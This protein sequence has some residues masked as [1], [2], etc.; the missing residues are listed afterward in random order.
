MSLVSSPTSIFP[1]LSIHVVVPVMSP[2][3]PHCAVPSPVTSGALLRPLDQAVRW[4]R[5]FPRHGVCGYHRPNLFKLGLVVLIYMSLNHYRCC[6]GFDEGGCR[7]RRNVSV[8][9]LVP[10]CWFRCR[11]RGTFEH[12]AE[13]STYCV[14]F[15]CEWLVV[16]VLPA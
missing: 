6:G 13:T 5:M 2:V 11:L 7:V 4:R 16:L 9:L 8:L 10:V 1:E 14:I 3:C 12:P 15:V